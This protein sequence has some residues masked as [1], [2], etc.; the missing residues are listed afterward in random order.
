MWVA[1]S[2]HIWFSA[3]V[4]FAFLALVHFFVRWLFRRKNEYLLNGRWHCVQIAEVGV[5]LLFYPLV[6]IVLKW[7]SLSIIHFR[8]TRLESFSRSAQ[9]FRAQFWI[10]DDGIFQLPSSFNFNSF[11][12][13]WHRYPEP[14][15]FHHLNSLCDSINSNNPHVGS[16]IDFTW[17]VNKI[18]CER[19]REMAARWWVCSFRCLNFISSH[20]L[21]FRVPYCVMRL[22]SNQNYWCWLSFF[23]AI[24]CA[25]NSRISCTVEICTNILIINE[26]GKTQK[27]SSRCWT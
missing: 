22:G 19:A 5:F 13:V 9:C 25:R 23:N 14:S 15:L 1:V 11:I 3:C 21:S 16:K 17:V 4:A 27:S 20:R 12:G 24:N 18:P 10:G 6:C 26:H 2:A 8:G 7:I